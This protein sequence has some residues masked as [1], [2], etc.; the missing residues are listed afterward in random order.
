MR[1]GDIF[2]FFNSFW[3]VIELRG[4]IILQKLRMIQNFC[5]IKIYLCFFVFYDILFYWCIIYLSYFIIYNIY[6]I[7]LYKLSIIY[8]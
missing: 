2:R 3:Y 1:Y 4:K 5:L 8:Q 6:F 7:T